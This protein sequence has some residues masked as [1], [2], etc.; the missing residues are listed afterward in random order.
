V[1]KEK[2]KPLTQVEDM[3]LHVTNHQLCRIKLMESISAS[4]C[5]CCCTLFLEPNWFT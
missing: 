2:S 3:K 1:W 4:C 5:C